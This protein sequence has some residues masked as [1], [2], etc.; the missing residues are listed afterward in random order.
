MLA[1]NGLAETV[2]VIFFFAGELPDPGELHARVAE[3][4]GDQARL[5]LVLDPPPNGYRRLYQHHRWAVAPGFDPAD[6]VLP[7]AEA[8]EPHAPEHAG[9]PMENLST[10][11]TPHVSRPMPASL[12]PWRLLPVRGVPDDGFAL[13]L[14][15]HHSLLDGSSLLTLLRLLLDGTPKPAGGTPAPAAPIC[16]PQQPMHWACLARA[17]RAELP[18]GSA[19]PDTLEGHAHPEVAFAALEHDNVRAA[20]GLAD[21]R[22]ATLNELLI[23]LTTGALR[24]VYGLPRPVGRRQ[25]PPVQATVPIDLRTRETAHHLGNIVSSVRIPLPLQAPTPHARLTACRQLLAKVPRGT[26]HQDLIRLGDAVNRLG[27]WVVEALAKRGYSPAYAAV[28]TTALKWR[29]PQA[30][31]GDR[32]LVRVAALPPLHQPGTLNFHAVASGH[33]VTLTVVSHT[34]QGTAH[35]LAD[36]VSCELTQMA[37]SV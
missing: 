5:R 35:T 10:L 16:T 7:V 12:P 17:L 32:P 28:N 21:G 11:L 37:R 15:S 31:L 29:H 23:A 2:G 19:L 13:V 30:H 22:G 33:T 6:H 3:R 9:N 20:C 18:R 4:W 24:S 8:G 27:P 34:R 25:V 26:A 14:L 1:R 36:A